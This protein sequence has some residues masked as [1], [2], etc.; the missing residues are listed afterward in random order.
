MA[1]LFEYYE[2]PRTHTNSLYGVY[3]EAQTFIPTMSH[4]LT[5]T[6]LSLKKVGTIGNVTVSLRA[7]SS[8]LPTGSD[9]ISV[10][11]A[12][13]TLDTS[14][15]WIT[16]TYDSSYAVVAGTEY[17]IVILLAGGDSSNYVGVASDHTGEYANGDSVYSTDSGSSW[18]SY[19]DDDLLFRNYGGY[20]S[21]E[22]AGLYAVVEERFHYVD[23]YGVERYIEGTVVG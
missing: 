6:Q 2:G 12:G 8:S 22:L 20:K 19:V 3:G 7:T 4:S 11:F 10:V 18:T 5:Y 13:S 1:A 23:A 9:L 15:G 14:Y 21:G 17:A 16:C